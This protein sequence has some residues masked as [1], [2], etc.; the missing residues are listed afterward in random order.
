MVSYI[1]SKSQYFGDELGCLVCILQGLR[2]VL[3]FVQKIRDFES[4]SELASTLRAESE[5]KRNSPFTRF[6]PQN[7][8]VIPTTMT[9]ISADIIFHLI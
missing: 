4:V 3:E 5:Y 8:C 1:P 9:F 7:T 6:H 2:D